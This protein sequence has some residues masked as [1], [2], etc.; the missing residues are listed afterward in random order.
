MPKPKAKAQTEGVKVTRAPKRPAESVEPLRRRIER[1][2]LGGLTTLPIQA[3]SALDRDAAALTE[4][5]PRA[6]AEVLREL[7]SFASSTERAMTGAR[8]AVDRLRFARAWLC[9][10]LDNDAARRRLAVASW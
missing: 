9:A 7:G 3:L 5:A 10:A 1:V 6:G 8:R 2:A 4:R